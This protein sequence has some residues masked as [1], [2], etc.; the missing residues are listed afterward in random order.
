MQKNPESAAVLTAR[1][2]AAENHAANAARSANDADMIADQ[3]ERAA[4]N[5]RK[6]AII[7][8]EKARQAREYAREAADLANL[9]DQEEDATIYEG[10]ALDIMR[11]MQSAHNLALAANDLAHNDPYQMILGDRNP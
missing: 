5:R 6:R 10:L 11:K 4:T 3:F 9:A 8:Q 2:N 7:A 1:V